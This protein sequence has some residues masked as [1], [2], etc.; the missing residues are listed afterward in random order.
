MQQFDLWGASTP[1]SEDSP[2]KTS[3]PQEQE[4][5]STASGLA[6]GSR[7]FE[8]FGRWSRWSSLL[9]TSLL[10]ELEEATG[11]SRVYI[12]KGTPG[13]LSWWV[14]GTSS[15]R[16]DGTGFLFSES[17]TATTDWPTPVATNNRKSRKAMTG[18]RENGR[19]SGGGNSS[20]PGLEQV[21][22]ISSG[23][24]PPEIEGMSFDEMSP[25]LQ[26]MTA[27][28]HWPTPRVCGGMNGSLN[29]A[30][31]RRN[32]SNLEEVVA[33][34]IWPTPAATPYGSSQNGING[35]GGKN[36][37]PSAG[38]PS[39]ETMAR[40]WPTPRANEAGK[41][42]SRANYGQ[43]C[44]ANHPAIVGKPTRA[45]ANKGD[46][47]AQNWPN[48]G[49]PG[50]ANRKPNGSRDVP[51]G[52]RQV[53]SPNWVEALMGFPTGYSLA[54]ETSVLKLWATP[55][56]RKSAKSSAEP[57]SPRSQEQEK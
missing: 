26:K 8:S 37:R 12:D 36:E 19:R 6:S 22:E 50:Q 48:D 55:S 43:V 32:K 41:V 30:Q 17:E 2:A 14:L 29:P 18:S 28:T 23:V 34:T 20:S 49:R 5:A 35:V 47:T 1:S 16:T 21:I 4:R 54:S 52:E 25:T 3:A 38:T 13:G 42:G 11:F 57:S 45:K 46:S 15:P 39:L 27:T 40:N 31:A 10:S 33:E 44:L 53:L 7:C 9:R 51:P 56:S 24:V